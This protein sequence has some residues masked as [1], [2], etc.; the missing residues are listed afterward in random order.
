MKWSNDPIAT[1]PT[2][3]PGDIPVAIRSQF[4]AVIPNIAL[5]GGYLTINGRFFFLLGR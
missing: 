5:N 2:L 3:V 4:I 1:A